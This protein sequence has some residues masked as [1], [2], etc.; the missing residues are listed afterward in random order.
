MQPSELRILAQKARFALERASLL[1]Q[2]AD[3]LQGQE[4]EILRA[5]A[6][7]SRRHADDL[8]SLGLEMAKDACGVA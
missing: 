4:A 2:Q 1:D 7:A 8:A 3:L 6:R 5:E